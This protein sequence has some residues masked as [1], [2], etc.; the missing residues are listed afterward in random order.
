VIEID[1]LLLQPR[2]AFGAWALKIRGTIRGTHTSLSPRCAWIERC[3]L[4]VEKPENERSASFAFVN[5]SL[6]LNAC[7]L[8]SAMV[9]RS[10]QHFWA[11]HCSHA[12]TIELGSGGGVP[13]ACALR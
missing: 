2:H 11:V 6:R 10:A 9:T 5:G 4:A 3:A 8:I 13:F 12:A 7:P 1:S